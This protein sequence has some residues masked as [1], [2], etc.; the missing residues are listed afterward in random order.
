MDI[1]NSPKFR[2]RVEQLMIQNHVPGLSIAIVQN[3]TI[4]SAGYGK[5]SL[6]PSKPCTADTIIGSILPSLQYSTVQFIS[7]PPRPTD[8]SVEVT[9]AYCYITHL[10]HFSRTLLALLTL[11]RRSWTLFDIAS[12]S[13]SLTAGAVGLLVDDD[14]K[15]PEVQY[16]A[17][18]SSLLPE[19]FVMC[20]GYTENVTVED[21]LSHR[22]GMAS[23]DSSYLGPRA[24]KPD[25]PQ[26]VTRNLRNLAV[27]APLRSK[28]HYC[29]MM[30]TVATYLVEK[31]SGQSFPDFLEEHFFQPL[32]M[33][34]TNLQPQR[35]RDKGLDER[36]ATGYAWN[37]DNKAYHGFQAP[38]C[39]EAQGAGSI[40][41]SV[42]DYIKWVKAIMNHEAPIT[43]DI[44]D[45]LVKPRAFHST[46]FEN[47]RPLTSLTSI[48][49]GWE[50]CFYRGYMVVSHDGS[51]PGFGSRHFFL[52]DFKFGGAIFGNS[53][54]AGIVAAIVAQEL[55]DEVLKVPETERPDWSKIESELGDDGGE[56]EEAEPQQHIYPGTKWSQPQERPLSAYTGEYSNPGYHDLT[57]QIKDDKLFV[58][59]MDRSFG[60]TLVFDHVREQIK[61]IARLCD[62]L[63]EGDEPLRAEFVFKGDKA[64]RMGL[65]LEIELEELIWFDR[66]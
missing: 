13:K 52:P 62:H 63:D 27:C 18:M 65:H 33:N 9:Y 59:A 53:G 32:D 37:E 42:N 57:V 4:A 51:V 38:D 1:F 21:I 55:I 56:E 17:T 22:T 19:D 47:L 64:V 6:D 23:H 28:Y 35:A 7:F 45:G 39:P 5:A 25:D 58:D 14:K 54:G 48:G 66:V 41:T 24:T 36:I 20:E 49:A 40:I 43:K 30:F 3:E 26:S 61:Y 2:S 8:R 46:S 16:E 44:Y 10:A 50:V 60:F 31:K 29:N 15:Y 11:A 12:A 34:S